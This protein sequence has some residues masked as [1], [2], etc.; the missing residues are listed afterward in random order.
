MISFSHAPVVRAMY[1]SIFL[2][3]ALLGA[4]PGVSIQ[5][6]SAQPPAPIAAA[7]GIASAPSDASSETLRT[8][9][10]EIFRIPRNA[11]DWIGMCFYVVLFIFSMIATTVGLERLFHLR[12][13]K[14]MP[15]ALM[16]Q[17]EHLVRTETDTLENLRVLA[18]SSDAPLARVLRDALLRAGR[19]LA[20]VEKG[21][22]DAM[23]REFLIL[24]GKQRGL[25][26]MANVGPLV[27]LFGTVVGMIF[28]FQM[29]SQAGLG[30]AELLAKGIYLAL[31]TTA[32]GLTIA[33]P[34]ILLLAYFNAKLDRYMVKM[35]GLLLQLLPSF[36]RMEQPSG[37][38]RS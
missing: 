6:A 34:C 38:Q 2:A 35:D 16:Q 4:L 1:R 31:L 32:L 24:R 12:R 5:P 36:A 19:P 14:V 26:V 8:L 28:A 37:S 21:I 11:T 17:L 27:G 3:V 33:V 20:E 18:G 22:E 29:A 9:G 7:A 23:A 10:Q 25:S 15:E 13:E 30:K